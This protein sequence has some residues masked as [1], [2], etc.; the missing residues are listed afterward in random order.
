MATQIANLLFK[1][2]DIL[3]TN[4]E[5]QFDP[6]VSVKFASEYYIIPTVFLT[7]YVL[8]CYFGTKVMKTKPAFDLKFPLAMWNLFLCLFSFVGMCRTVGFQDIS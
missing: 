5:K 4:F 2:C 7:A 3:S 8:F 1:S 6:R